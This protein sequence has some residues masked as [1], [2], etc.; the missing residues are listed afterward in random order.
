MLP[1]IQTTILKRLYIICRYCGKATLGGRLPGKGHHKGDG[2]F[3]YPRRHKFKDNDC[4]G[5]IV[6]GTW[7]EFPYI[8]K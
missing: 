4:P 2:S 6:E 1:H 3:R 8:P 5:N 7:S